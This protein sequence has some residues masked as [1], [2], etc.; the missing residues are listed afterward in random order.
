MPT[1]NVRVDTLDRRS[2]FTIDWEA[3]DADAIIAELKEAGCVDVLMDDG[4]V[5]IYPLATIRKLTV[6]PIKEDT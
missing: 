3:D 4:S 1:F 6:L 5:E 2:S